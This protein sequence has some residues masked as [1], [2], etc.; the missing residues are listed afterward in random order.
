M[1]KIRE[2]TIKR[3][4]NKKVSEYYN[5]RGW[6][7]GESGK[8]LDEEVNINGA[9]TSKEYTSK[10][11]DKVVT[12]IEKLKIKKD[13]ILDVGCGAIQIKERQEHSR[14]FNERH[15]VDFSQKALELAKENLINSKQFNHFFYNLDFLENDFDSNFFDTAISMHVLYHVNISMQEKFVRELIRVTKLDGQVLIAYSNPF[16]LTF[17]LRLP[18]EILDLIKSIVKKGL[19]VTRGYEDKNIYFRRKKIFWWRRFDD[20]CDVKILPLKTFNGQF[21]HKYIP[22]SNFGKRIY[23]FLFYLESFKFWRFFS[24]YYLV[25]LKVNK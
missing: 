23:N 6:E 4:I 9:I 19:S 15:C 8:P 12:E 22:D 10:V 14:N 13:K 3:N 18:F 24:E 2:K 17:F 20:S 25:I 11:E 7:K 5:D 16:C 1:P 21:E